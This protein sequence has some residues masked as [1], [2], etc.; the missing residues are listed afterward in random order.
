MHLIATL[1]QTVIPLHET[2]VYVLGYKFIA[3]MPLNVDAFIAKVRRE[4]LF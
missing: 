1:F 3:G 2:N 4:L